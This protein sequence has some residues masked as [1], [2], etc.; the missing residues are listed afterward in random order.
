MTPRVLVS[1][2]CLGQPMGGVVRHNRELLPRIAEQLRA[3]GGGMEVLEGR[4]PIRFKLP[5]HVV[6]HRSGV[7]WLPTHRRALA[8]SRALRTVL[9]ESAQ[10]GRPF[11]LVHTAHQPTP[12]GLGTPM[13]L[14]IH[15]LRSLDLDRTS[16]VRRALGRGVLARGVRAAARIGC[17]SEWMR[18]RIEAEFPA[19]QGKVR[20]I[21]NGADHLP[22]LARADGSAR[23]AE[24]FLLHVG[25]LEPRKN[26]DLLVRA[27]AVDPTLPRLV[28]VGTS[29]VDTPE[30]LLGLAAALGVRDRIEFAG[31]AEDE[32]LARYYSS[33][34]CAVFPSRLEGF[35][36]GV[37]E[38]QRAGCPVA[39]SSIPAHEEHVQE[40]SHRFGIDDPEGCAR[41]IACASSGGPAPGAAAPRSWD[42]CADAWTAL[43]VEA[44]AAS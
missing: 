32:D 2:T 12:R 34:T 37:V 13:T 29:R 31:G 26:L 42:A 20:L 44:A 8:E 7:P 25:H 16:L 11:D 27:L 24:P 19:A 30:R 39:V 14:T 41:A 40:P 21:G 33:A 36:I 18:S 6:V 38:A 15:D 22:L 5:D 17:V 10:G 35:G 4:V 43:L 9:R 1:G 23:A 28:L 3:S